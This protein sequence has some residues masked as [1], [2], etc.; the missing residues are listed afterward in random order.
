MVTSRRQSA[1]SILQFLGNVHVL[2]TSRSTEKGGTVSKLLATHMGQ[3]SVILSWSVGNLFHLSW[4]SN[5]SYWVSQPAKILPIAHSAFG[6]HYSSISYGI[7]S[8]GYSESA[9]V[10]TY[11]GICHWMYTVGISSEIEVYNLCLVIELLAVALVIVA[12]E[13]IKINCSCVSKYRIRETIRSSSGYRFNCHVGHFLGLSS[14]IWS[15]HLIHVAIPTSRGIS[16]YRFG[17]VLSSFFNG[18]WVDY[19]MGIDH[20]FHVHLSFQGSGLDVLTFSGY[21]GRTSG[22]LLLSDILHHHMALAGLLIWSSHMYSSV[23]SSVGTKSRYTGASY[24]FP[25]CA[26]FEPCKSLELELSVALVTVSLSSSFTAQHIYS[27]SPYTYLDSDYVTTVA[28]FLT[29]CRYLRFV[30]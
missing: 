1:N 20:P 9:S 7:C 28:L 15:A 8:S 22:S 10:L 18:N 19:S 12:V 16:P 21:V 30:W 29:T 14:L 23:F 27:I 17:L 26:I 3:I 24:G 6:P 25:L 13:H 11:S 4:G 5:Y 2:H